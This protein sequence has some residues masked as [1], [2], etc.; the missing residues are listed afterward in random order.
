MASVFERVAVVLS[1]MAVIHYRTTVGNVIAAAEGHA[2]AHE[3][4]APCVEAPAEAAKDSQPDSHAEANSEADHHADRDRCDEKARVGDHQ[5]SINHPGIV[6]RNGHQ[7]RIDRR[8]CD[9]AALHHHRL[10]RRG[11]QDV[12]FLRRK[13]IGLDRV[14]H[15]FRLVE[16]RVTELRGPTGVLRQIIQDGG[17]RR[18]TLEGRIPSHGVRRGCSLLDGHPQIGV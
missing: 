6:I 9:H 18:E 12:P 11:N 8:D 3:V 15:V 7:K 14:H 10:L 17:K 16:I 1:K 13:T 4:R 5:R 2:A